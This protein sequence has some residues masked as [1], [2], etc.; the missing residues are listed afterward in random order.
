MSHRY[1]YVPSLLIFLPPLLVVTEHKI[2]APWVIQQILEVLSFIYPAIYWRASWLLPSFG[3][4][5]RSWCPYPCASF[6]VSKVLRFFGKIPRS[7]IAGS[8]SKSTFSFVRNCPLFSSVTIPFYVPSGDGGEF[9]LFLLLVSIWYCCC[10]TFWAVWCLWN[11]VLLFW[12]EF[13]WWPLMWSIFSSAYCPFL[14][15]L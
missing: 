13:P 5:E 9:L 12:F 15:L 4:C 10:F 11:G 1:T 14:Y 2:R 7:M 8:C 6:C 3:N